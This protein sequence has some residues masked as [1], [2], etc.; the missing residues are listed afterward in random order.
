MMSNSFGS[1]LRRGIL[2][3]GLLT[4][5][6]GGVHAADAGGRLF[7][8]EAA[9]TP[10]RI[11]A[12][13][14]VPI[15][16]IQAGDAELDTADPRAPFT[17]SLPAV[18]PAVAASRPLQVHFAITDTLGRAVSGLTEDNLRFALAK[19]IPGSPG[20]FGVAGSGE[21]GEWVSYI[22]RTKS[23]AAITDG[24]Q[25]T[26]ESGT[27]GRLE[28]NAAGYYTYTFGTDVETATRPDSNQRIWD[29]AATH[30][31]AI[32]LEVRDD[33]GERILYNPHFDFSFRNRVSAAVTDPAQTRMVAD[34]S[35]CN[36]CHGE[37]AAH[38]GRNQV[39]YCVMCHNP[40]SVDVEFGS[41]IDFDVMIHKIH[42]GKSLGEAYK[43]AGYGGAVHEW[44]EV[45]YPQD[46]R[47]CSKC[48][49]GDNPAT[50]QG[51]NWQQR[52]TQQ[53]CSACH[54]EVDFN[55]HQGYDFVAADG[56]PDNSGCRACHGGAS[57]DSGIAN[58]HWSQQTGHTANYRFNI[59]NLD[60]AAASRQAT[61]TYS[62]TN[63]NDGTAYDLQQGLASCIADVS[64][65]RL[66]ANDCRDLDGAPFSRFAL[67]IASLT[68]EGATPGIDDYTD[69]SPEVYAW[70]GT[71]NGDGSYTASLT[72]P[73][74]AR[75]TA[76]LI[77]SGQAQ[78]RRITDPFRYR[79]AQ[80]SGVAVTEVN[81]AQAGLDWAWANRVRV[82]VGN[83]FEEFSVDGSPLNARR[84]VVSTAKCN[85]CH[86][87]LGGMTAS[88]IVENAFHRGERSEVA[89]CPVCH[90]P[91]RASGTEMSDEIIGDRVI[92]PL[93][94]ATAIRMNQSYEFKN[95]IHGIHGGAARVTPFTHYG[96]DLSGKTHYPN[97]LSNC[98]ACHLEGS[99][100]RNA[101]KLGAAVS[102]EDDLMQRAVYS[103]YAAA[104]MGCHDSDAARAHVSTIG[105]GGAAV[106]DYTQAEWLG[107]RVYERCAECHGAGGARDVM[108]V[109]GLD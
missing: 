98:T 82:P 97:I 5:I 106:G 37:L 41:P 19:L 54:L 24:V 14:S 33:S 55:A 90:T 49:S 104:C 74:A 64:N 86:G 10:D 26:Y 89:S 66:S 107:G 13:E 22:Y 84:E 46:L 9:P 38:G 56:T 63:P 77:S 1:V 3:A 88:N 40:G 30:R 73:E 43:I 50:P 44:S 8:P 65:G 4:G 62:L 105:V 70:M 58:V 12:H 72:V 16:A 92:P 21:S 75:G 7:D 93:L 32:Q 11:W 60:Y 61:V 17:R 103:P 6:S 42:M 79:R 87:V 78:E 99:Y 59:L 27:D 35:A 23:G 69:H 100:R 83:A 102:R 91:N 15:A 76:R 57:R 51:D 34:E 67:Y 96:N 109:H 81:A 68:L 48:H 29:P 45:G 31:I 101:G 53:A 47:N 71:P 36:S 39:E 2:F 25:A 20:Y 108:A 85:N 80:R 94:P 95:M 52:P 28:Y 18:V